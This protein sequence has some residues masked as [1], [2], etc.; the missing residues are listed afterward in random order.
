MKRVSLGVDIGLS[1]AAA[2]LIEVDGAV[3][4][5][6]AIDIPVIGDGA[7]RRVNVLALQE[8]LRS[9]GPAFAFCERAKSMPRQGVASTFRYG[10]SAGSI[11]TTIQLCGVPFE[12]IEPMRWKKF[13][14]LVGKDK[15]AS[16]QRALELFPETHALLS[17]KRDHNIAEACLIGLYGL[18]TSRALL[19]PAPTPVET[20]LPVESAS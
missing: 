2:I 10:R 15:E 1:G 18:R 9:H 6:S 3:T 8:W 12:L 5:V 14:T 11:E 4:V 7:S 13:F 16:R 19:Q 20:T 17:R